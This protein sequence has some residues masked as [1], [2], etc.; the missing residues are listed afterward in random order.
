MSYAPRIAGRNCTFHKIQLSLVS[1]SPTAGPSTVGR[2]V[3]EPVD[4]FS[5]LSL[6]VFGRGGSGTI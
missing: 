3:D 5:P 4:M 1:F 6:D 2:D